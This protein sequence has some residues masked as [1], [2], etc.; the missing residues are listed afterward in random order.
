MA[1]FVIVSLALVAVALAGTVG[2]ELRAGRKSASVSLP[3]TP[4]RDLPTA[5][6]TSPAVIVRGDR[7]S[8]ETVLARPPFSPSRRPS[9][10]ASVAPAQAARAKLPRLAGIMMDG[11]RRSVIF[12]PEG[13]R[14]PIIVA[15]GGELD[16]FRVER[17]EAGMVTVS[18]PGVHQVL[19]PS[20]DLS[21]S[22]PRPVPVVAAP[23]AAQPPGFGGPPGL[24]RMPGY[25][26]NGAGPVTPTLPGLPSLSNLTGIPG[27]EPPPGR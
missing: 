9:A 13:D 22:P 11:A 10:V 3:S 7:A 23:P 25:V 27:L 5:S 20:F 4:V 2:L 14:R 8:V 1:R 15:E 24:E 26:P 21:A 16:G 12:A 6:A 18:G 19:R 17:I